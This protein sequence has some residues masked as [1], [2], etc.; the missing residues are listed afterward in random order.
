VGTGVFLLPDFR[1]LSLQLLDAVS[2]FLHFLLEL[3]FA[4][5][6]SAF[7][8]LLDGFALQ[9]VEAVFE[10]AMV[11]GSV[12]FAGVGAFMDGELLHGGDWHGLIGFLVAAV[13]GGGSLASVAF[14]WSVLSFFSTH[15]RSKGWE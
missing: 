15:G 8:P 13:G 10:G 12:S 7:G 9:E 11:F 4:L 2:H 3:L 14:F 5:A 1:Q 6:F